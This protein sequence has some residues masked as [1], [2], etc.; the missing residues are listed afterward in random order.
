M[1]SADEPP[2][3]FADQAIREQLQNPAWCGR[4]TAGRLRSASN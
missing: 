3:D 1:P 4:F 2:H